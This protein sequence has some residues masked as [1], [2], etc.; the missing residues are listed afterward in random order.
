M[1]KQLHGLLA[2]VAATVPMTGV[3][4]VGRAVG[5]LGTPPPEQIT[6]AAAAL[7]DVDD[8]LPPPVFDATWVAAHLAYGGLCGAIYPS[9]RALLP[10]SI[11]AAGLAYGLAVWGA[12][13]VGLM[14]ALRLYPSPWRDRPS[15]TA[16]MVAAH[17]V[18]GIALAEAHR[19]LPEPSDQ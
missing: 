10:S 19:L 4:A 6:A 15:R 14:P 3:I 7:A 16:V 18:F 17:A 1:T 13:Y 2:G 9:L 11:P 12:S 5:W 8:D